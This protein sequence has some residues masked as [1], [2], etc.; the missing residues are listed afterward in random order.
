MLTYHE[1]SSW[2]NAPESW[3][4]VLWV[5]Q[6]TRSTR[7]VA[8]GNT[9]TGSTTA[10]T[11]IQAAATTESTSQ[12]GG[13]SPGTSAATYGDTGSTTASGG[14]STS[15]P[16]T[17]ST[18]PPSVSTSSGGIGLSSLTD[19]TSTRTATISWPSTYTTT[20]HLGTFP[21]TT[22]TTTR[23]AATGV[24]GTR[25]ETYYEATT[26]PEISSTETVLA[27][28]ASVSTLSHVFPPLPGTVIIPD[29]QGGPLFNDAVAWV[30]TVTDTTADSVISRFGDFFTTTASGNQ[31]AT[32]NW[33]GRTFQRSTVWQTYS[34]STGTQQITETTTG[35]TSTQTGTQTASASAA[36]LNG[37]PWDEDEAPET[38]TVW[39]GDITGSST[40]TAPGPVTLT[41]YTYIRQTTTWDAFSNVTTINTTATLFDPPF[42]T[43][44]WNTWQRSITASSTFAYPRSTSTASLF[45][46]FSTN[47]RECGST[48]ISLEEWQAL[49]NTTSWT[50]WDDKTSAVLNG[51]F[52]A[53]TTA[54]ATTSNTTSIVS[55]TYHR[56]DYSEVIQQ[57][58]V[59]DLTVFPFDWTMGSR[60]WQRM[61]PKGIYGFGDGFEITSPLFT[62][63]SSTLVDGEDNTALTLGSGLP[64]FILHPDA[65]AF[66]TNS[67]W[68]HGG[69]WSHI[70]G[71]WTGSTAGETGP[72]TTASFLHRWVSTGT[73]TSGTDTVTT[74]ST[75]S[76]TY[77][78]SMAGSITGDF[79]SEYPPKQ[80][81]S[82]DGFGR[83]Y[84]SGFVGGCMGGLA[85][86]SSIAQT[87]TFPPGG[88]TLT[89]ETAPGA[90][91]S[92]STSTSTGPI[93]IA[94]PSATAPVAYSWEHALVLSWV[95]DTALQILEATVH[96]LP[97]YPY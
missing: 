21:D 27:F 87:A 67:C 4:S 47:S 92:S 72:R 29:A 76:A 35:T 39:I 60:V 43:T 3:R 50:S 23:T 57:A 90:T 22:E 25:T 36:S 12:A 61:L 89:W 55:Q 78:V 70:S 30:P 75:V 65:S 41:D 1:S 45:P 63:V 52:T 68:N 62:G 85:P 49:T 88:L 44:T 10:A 73:T 80:N 11:T 28:G 42:F 33:S 8:G 16:Y 93:T 51:N 7:R 17:R 96:D 2:H 94:M 84:F 71:T 81:S 53:S 24:T 83:P 15:T 66:V 9:T 19:A 48:S 74:S 69:G 56:T 59:S 37:S 32:V 82:D 18:A 20:A 31:T 13:G 54:G 77:G 26:G 5:T 86:I 34:L 6:S 95:D 46:S 40:Y 14:G 97:E 38:S 91:S 64:K 58:L 79:W